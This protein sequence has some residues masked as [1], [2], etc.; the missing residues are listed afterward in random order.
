[1]T[2]SECFHESSVQ[3]LSSHDSAGTGESTSELTYLVVNLSPYIVGYRPE[4]LIASY[5]WDTALYRDLLTWLLASTE[6]VRKKNVRKW[7]K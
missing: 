6:D 7:L 4:T 1:M 2:G 5:I 3:F